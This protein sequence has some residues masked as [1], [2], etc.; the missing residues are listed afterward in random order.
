MT[1]SPA[2]PKPSAPVEPEGR[3][4]LPPPKERRRLR[5]AVSL[6]QAQF[7]TLVGVT[8][9]TVR[10]WE[11]GRTEPRGRRRAAYAKLLESLS[12]GADA[13]PASP[14]TPHSP[15]TPPSP[16]TPHS[17]G[18]PRSGSSEAA[19]PGHGLP[20]AAPGAGG[21]AGFGGGGGSR[22][23]A[24]AGAG[25]GA[26]QRIRTAPPPRTPEEAFD[27][28]CV[29]TA[30]ALLRQTYALTGHRTLAAEAVDRALQLAWQRWPEVAT[31]GDPP[32]W[33][34][35]AAYEYALSPWHR[36]RPGLRLTDTPPT[37]V[38][39]R[40]VLAALRSLS[41]AQRRTLLL[42]DGLGLDLP[43]TAAETEAST[44]ATANRLLRARASVAARLPE[45]T[46]EALPARLAA[47]GS[48]EQLVVPRPARLRAAGERR[49]RLWTRAAV[50]FTTLIIGA[51]ALT[52]RTAPTHY[53]PPQSPGS[54]ISDVPPLLGPGPLTPEDEA[55]RHELS[56][57]PH[58][59]PHR[60]LPDT[61]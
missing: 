48:A 31:D 7:A 37:D 28:L 3:P 20:G 42:Y 29:G 9:A 45:L 16:A 22:S 13:P 44:P 52:L 30:P 25:F 8:R 35:A 11:A 17:P 19:D 51:T 56:T 5:E 21:R 6:T 39:D 58:T 23:G 49:A 43:D 54:A 60:L 15:G 1:Q 41:P 4:S 36:F 10:A 34:R 61:R 57:Q 2:S 26:G 32:G 53:E 40:A 12:T 24:G 47:L 55:L 14:E 59:G 18:T 33:V 50:V 38:S 46:A 27:T